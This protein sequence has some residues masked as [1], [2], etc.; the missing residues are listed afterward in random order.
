[1]AAIFGLPIYTI[2]GAALMG[3]FITSVAG[4]GIYY[5]LVPFYPGQAVAPDLALGVLFGIGGFCGMYIGARMQKFI[6]AN[7]IRIGLGII[8]SGLALQYII[9][10]FL[11]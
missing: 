6:K 3:T 1:V 9:G 5:S 8:I 4:V 2:A 10:F 7:I 11:G